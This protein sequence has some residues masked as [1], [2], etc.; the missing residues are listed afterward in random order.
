MGAYMNDDEP[1]VVL[2]VSIVLK[3]VEKYF[4]RFHFI[5]VSVFP[6]RSI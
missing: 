1:L 4:H 3:Y 2:D 5:G 6:V